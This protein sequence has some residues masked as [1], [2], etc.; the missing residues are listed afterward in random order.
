M[1]SLL[2]LG[3]PAATLVAGLTIAI[4]SQRPWLPRRNLRQPIPFS[5]RVHAGE[6]HIPCEYCHAYARISDFAGV[7]PIERC[8]GCHGSLNWRAIQPATRPWLDR[9]KSP[10]EVR[11]NRV[12]VLPSF[13]R[14]SHRIHIHEKIACQTCH[15]PVQEMDRVEPVK[16]L[17]MG[18][19]IGC[20]TRRNV[21]R[22]CFV[23]HY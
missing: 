22:Q 10:F 1:R 21:S 13:V 4:F 7:P 18:F 2:L 3:L 14:F 6:R 12:Y 11:W 5:H 19:C 15:G 17:N 16:D 20:H 8:E 9:R 23:C